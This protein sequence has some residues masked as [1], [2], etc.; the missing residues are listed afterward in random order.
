MARNLC[1]IPSDEGRTCPFMAQLS[2][3][4]GQQQGGGTYPEAAIP[5]SWS[6]DSLESSCTRHLEKKI[7]GEQLGTYMLDA[8]CSVPW[9][10]C[11]SQLSELESVSLIRHSNS[12]TSRWT[13]KLK[14]PISTASNLCIF[15]IM[16]HIFL[17]PLFNYGRIPFFMSAPVLSQC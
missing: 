16:F 15:P 10:S 6:C 2:W 9:L 7:I 13:G 4:S 8:G 14:W 3:W 5:C 17:Y 12:I 1:A 11:C